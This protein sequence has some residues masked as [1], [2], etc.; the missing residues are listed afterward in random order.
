M[1]RFL[2]KRLVGLAPVV[3]VAIIVTFAAIRALPG[4]PVA[5][6]LSDHSADVEM[7]ARLR[8]EYGLDQP[9]ILQFLHYLADIAT[10]N[11]G[12]SFRYVHMPVSAVLRDS[13]A[14]S[15]LL[16]L[17]ALALALPVGVIAGT[18]AAIHRN[19][20]QDTAIILALVAGPT[21]IRMLDRYARKLH[22]TFVPLEQT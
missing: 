1:L 18:Q 22:G 19:R 13:L 21:L 8:A 5:V 20:F 4:D 10:G 9:L 3:A 16:A 12:L 15:P 6:M 2:G 14:I 7:A 11:F 17:A